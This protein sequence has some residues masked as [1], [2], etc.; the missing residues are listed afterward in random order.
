LGRIVQT[1]EIARAVVFLASDDASF[2][3]GRPLVL[4]GGLLAVCY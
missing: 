4:D 3:N 2:M 1:G